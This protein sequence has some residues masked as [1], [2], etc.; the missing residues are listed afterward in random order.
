MGYLLWRRERLPLASYLALLPLTALWSPLGLMGA[1]PFAALAGI[2]T[3]AAR[4]LRIA[5]ML[6]PALA[7]LLAVPS[8]LYLGAASG[9]DVGLRFQP[10]PP[11]QWLMFQG[12]ETLPYLVPLLLVAR[13]S[14]FGRDTL[15]LAFAWLMLIP[16]VQIGWSIDFMARASI[17]A[18]AIL[19]AMLADELGNGT[20]RRTWLIAMLLIGSLTGLAEIRRALVHPPAPEVRCSVSKAWDQTFAAFPKGS[21]FAPLPAMPAL[22]R[23]ARPTP[24]PASE[25][26]RCWDGLWFSPHNFRQP[27]SGGEN[28]VK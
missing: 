23:P 4:R 20:E 26:A 15:W 2:R 14:R 6:L 16:F 5:D 21:Y 19:A 8:L 22:V 13:P 18:L 25:P 27:G 17:A 10:I 1:M 24:V 11:L 12:I 9:A 3:L 7:S 28:R